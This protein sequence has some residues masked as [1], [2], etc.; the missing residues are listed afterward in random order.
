MKVELQSIKSFMLVPGTGQA[1]RFAQNGELFAH[2][3][4]DKRVCEDTAE[5]R[6]VLFNVNSV[7]LLPVAKDATKQPAVVCCL[8]RV[9]YIA[10]TLDC[11]YFTCCQMV[12]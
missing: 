11:F 7:Y 1:A 9:D 3:A 10:A 12:H 8:S 4:L 2:V 6:L 5:G